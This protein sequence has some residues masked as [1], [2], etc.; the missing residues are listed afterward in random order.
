MVL[1][2]ISQKITRAGQILEQIG[3][4][5]NES[6]ARFERATG[7]DI[8][9]VGTQLPKPEPQQPPEQKQEPP[10]PPESGELKTYRVVLPG[11]V[12]QQQIKEV[13]EQVGGRVV[14][15]PEGVAI[16]F[17]SR[18]PPKEVKITPYEEIAKRREEEQTKELASKLYEKASLP[19]K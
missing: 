10:S 9:L 13:L 12:H 4:N 5:I 14:G 1:D 3:K 17:E 16:E 19:E 8:P 18:S 15:T 11:K 6:I 7:I 2:W